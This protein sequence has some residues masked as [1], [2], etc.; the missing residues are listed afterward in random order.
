MNFNS[1]YYRRELP[2]LLNS[3][4]KE[5]RKFYT[6][7]DPTNEYGYNVNLDRYTDLC[8]FKE[9]D[10]IIC[11]IV[12]DNDTIEVQDTNAAANVFL[13]MSLLSDRKLINNIKEKEDEYTEDGIPYAQT[14]KVCYPLIAMRAIKLCDWYMLGQRLMPRVIIGG[15]H[16][17]KRFLTNLQLDFGCKLPGEIPT[18][19]FY[20]KIYLSIVPSPGTI[21]SIS[22]KYFSSRDNVYIEKKNKYSMD[23]ENKNDGKKFLDWMISCGVHANVCY[24]PSM[25]LL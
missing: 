1:V 6:E 18:N 14:E 2:P 7:S 16:E 12:N 15:E 9:L 11:D 19:E 4:I 5:L 25:N 3:C 24:N 13:F 8:P 22:K 23:A 20:D 17:I 21:N 10:S